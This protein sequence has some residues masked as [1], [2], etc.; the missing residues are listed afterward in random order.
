MNPPHMPGSAGEGFALGGSVRLDLARE[1]ALGTVGDFGWAG[2][3]STWF[4][5]DPREKMAAILF[6]QHLPMDGA[7]FSVYSTLVYQALAE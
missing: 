7:A 5:I 6:M 1:S 3:A 4:R 2:A